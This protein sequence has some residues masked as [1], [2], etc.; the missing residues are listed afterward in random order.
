CQ[1]APATTV[2]SIPTKDSL[3]A[4]VEKVYGPAAEQIVESA[5]DLTLEDMLRFQAFYQEHWADNAVSYTAI[6]DPEKYE[7]S[8][9]M[10]TLIR[11]GGVRKDARIFAEM[12][13]PQGPY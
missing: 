2:V 1:Y 5:A 11:F 6:V 12:G 8:E 9:L 13:R 7:V 4:E 10:E 3:L